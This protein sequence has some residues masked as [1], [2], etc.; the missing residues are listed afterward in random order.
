MPLRVKPLRDFPRVWHHQSTTTSETPSTSS[1]PGIRCLG[2]LRCMKQDRQLGRQQVFFLLTST[3]LAPDS[4]Q[5]LLLSRGR[6]LSR[7]KLQLR[8]MVATVEW[9]WKQ[10]HLFIYRENKAFKF[11][12]WHYKTR[13][14]RVEQNSFHQQYVPCDFSDTDSLYLK[15]ALFER[16]L[17]ALYIKG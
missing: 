12:P 11:N 17:Q 8:A 3:L 2:W 6:E 16:S 13:S 1:H 7:E 9:L 5:K 10:P 15:R 14:S 4:K